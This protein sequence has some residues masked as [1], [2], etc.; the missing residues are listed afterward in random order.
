MKSGNNYTGMSSKFGPVKS[1]SYL[2][3]VGKAAPFVSS[4]PL[5]RS[6]PLVKSAAPVA[7]AAAAANSF[8]YMGSL[9]G[10]NAMKSGKNFAGVNQKFAATRSGNSYLDQVKGAKMEP[11]Q[12]APAASTA[13]SSYVSSFADAPASNGLNYMG[14]L[15]GGNAMKN[16]KNFA[17][18]GSTF[19]SAKSTNPYL[20]SVKNGTPVQSTTSYSGN[21]GGS[22]Y[23]SASY[24]DPAPAGSGGAVSSS[25][26]SMQSSFAAA[27]G[28]A[29]PVSTNGYLETL[30]AGRN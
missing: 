10:G 24:V 4:A 11:S 2:D 23:S 3:A 6:A 19:G 29:A 21:A 26:S 28:A 13:A 16:G 15:G 9:G 14:S 12:Y 25:Y 30:K 1:N 20:E 18:V 8:N 5:A 7:S 22:S 17:G 27:T